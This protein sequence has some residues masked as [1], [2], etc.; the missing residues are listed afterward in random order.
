MIFWGGGLGVKSSSD[1]GLISDQRQVQNF[2][3]IG[4]STIAEIFAFYTTII[5]SQNPGKC[6]PGF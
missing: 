3:R 4:I 1:R 6:V 2:R 5:D